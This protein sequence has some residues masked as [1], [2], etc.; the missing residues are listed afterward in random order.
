M[1]ADGSH[2]Q[3]LFLH[4]ENE[5]RLDV[6]TASSGELFFDGIEDRY[7]RLLDGFRV[8]G[9]PDTLDFRLM[10]FERNDIRVPPRGADD[11]RRDEALLTTSALKVSTGPFAWAELTW[12]LGIPVLA[13]D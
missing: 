5:G 2:F 11:G 8:E 4:S 10:R 9:S 3:R 6:I 1:N 12:G 7:L 13:G